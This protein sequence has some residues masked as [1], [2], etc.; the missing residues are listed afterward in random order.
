MAEGSRKPNSVNSITYVDGVVYIHV[1]HPESDGDVVCPDCHSSNVT[2][3]KYRYRKPKH[4]HVEVPCR[5]VLKVGK[6][7]C[8]NPGCP[9]KY[10]TRRVREAEP[11]ARHSLP[12]KGKAKKIYRRGNTSLRE[13]ET[14]M[15]EDFHNS[16]GKSSILRWHQKGLGEDYPEPNKLS[17]SHILVVDETFSRT[18][19]ERDYVL[20]CVDPVNHISTHLIIDKLDSDSIGE[21]LQVIKGLGADP[22]VIVSDLAAYYPE[23]FAQVWPKAK[24]QLCWFHV[25]QIVNK[26]LW[27]A[28]RNYTKRL[29]KEEA[30][31]IRKSRWKLLSGR[32][33]LSEKDIVLLR[34]LMASHR[35]SVL[36]IGTA[37]RDGLREVMNLNRDKTEARKALEAL[38]GEGGR[39]LANCDPALAH[40]VSL[41]D[42]F[43][44]QMIT[45]LDDRQ[46]P[47]TSNIAERDNRRWRA[48]ERKRYGWVTKHGKE[49]FL[50]VMQGYRMPPRHPPDP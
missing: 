2:L 11:Y 41:F 40:I 43:F 10:F 14:Y 3:H 1:N 33:R 50:V 7:R 24:R 32:E 17:F 27:E 37:L 19:G 21:G 47:R 22:Q 28:I 9:R 49:A 44:E 20:A 45:Y 13:A 35:D 5:L 4:I 34:E 16:A 25:M 42:S 38:L 12:A 15:R 26:Y 18:L 36:E 23:A 6:Y 29:D 8:L 39:E 31:R 46:I 48:I 30:K